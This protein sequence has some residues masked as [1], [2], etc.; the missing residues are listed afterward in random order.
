ML[1]LWVDRVG[2]VGCCGSLRGYRIGVGVWCGTVLVVW[3]VG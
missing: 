3:R 1:R 2:C